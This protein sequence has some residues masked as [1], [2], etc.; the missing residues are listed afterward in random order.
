VD[1]FV[2]IGIFAILALYFFSNMSV[3]KSM[4][5]KISQESDIVNSEKEASE[6]EIKKYENRLKS[7]IETIR[8]TEKTLS[9]SREENQ[10]LKHDIIEYKHRNSLLQERI[11]DLY[12]SVGM[13]Q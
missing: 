10:K 8:D 2:L 9:K 7:A 12:S 4:Y 11:D 13:I 5:S 6:Q 1:N 3:Y